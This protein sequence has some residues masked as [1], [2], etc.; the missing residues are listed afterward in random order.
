LTI[1]FADT[2]TV[3]KRYIPETGTTWVLSWIAP[4]NG[5]ITIIAQIALVEMFSMLERRYSNHQLTRPKV[6][7]VQNYFLSHAKREYI[8]TPIDN[9]LIEDAR[10]LV[11]K[12]ASHGLRA[13]DAIQLAS[14]LRA[15]NILGE[16]LTFVT[17]DAKL[18]NSAH[19]EGFSV[20]NPE[21]HP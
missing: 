14:A 8:V 20:D 10:Q 11:I 16:T 1:Y 18:F 5:A 7:K 17:A 19:A 3:A 9:D 15:T 6:V 13:M 2:S 12:H 21:T 4:K